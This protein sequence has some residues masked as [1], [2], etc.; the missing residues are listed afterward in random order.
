M[1]LRKTTAW[2]A[3]STRRKSAL[4]HWCACTDDNDLSER[5]TVSICYALSDTRHI[6]KYINVLRN[7]ELLERITSFM[8]MC[9][10]QF[11][12]PTDTIYP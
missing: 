10:R 1:I 9:G 11:D 2:A 3:H 6:T 4:I 8:M 5:K 7:Y 12:T